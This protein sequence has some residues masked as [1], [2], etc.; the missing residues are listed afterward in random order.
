[1]PG[2]IRPQMGG[3]ATVATLTSGTA[4]TFTGEGLPL[5]ATV[6]ARPAAGDSITVWYSTDNGANYNV[7]AAGV[8]TVYAEDVLDS[9][10]TN[11]RFQRTA[12]SGTTSTCG[13]C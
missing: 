5:P 4:V 9:G 12:G 2:T 7:W 8:I 3:R 11:I 13:V 6:W 1:M 10:V